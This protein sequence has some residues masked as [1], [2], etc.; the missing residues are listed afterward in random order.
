[1][2]ID[3]YEPTNIE[4]LIAQSLF[5]AR[6]PLNNNGMSDYAWYTWQYELEQA[7][8]KQ[9]SELLGT[10]DEVEYQLGR[11]LMDAPDTL[12]NQYLIIEGIAQGIPE[13]IQTWKMHDNQNYYRKS[14]RFKLSMTRYEAYL[15][16]LSRAGVVVIKTESWE[17]TATVLVQLEKSAQYESNILN[18]HLKIRPDFRPN[19]YVEQLMGIKDIGPELAVKLIEI[20]N[21]PW[22]IYSTLPQVI[23][24][25]VPGMGLKGATDLLRKIGKDV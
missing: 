22:K 21:T 20:F 2:L 3:T 12:L 1:M 18:R 23:A 19:P 17:D 4:R 5:T 25:Y 24:D 16:A 11:Q 7:E 6:G 14:T 8:R 9:I 15:I 10:I 13:G